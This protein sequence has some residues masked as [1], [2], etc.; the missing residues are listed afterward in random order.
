M[1]CFHKN[2]RLI[3]D[4]PSNTSVD[5]YILDREFIYSII[6]VNGIIIYQ[7]DKSKHF[8]RYDNDILSRIFKLS[9]NSDINDFLKCIRM[10]DVY[11]KQVRVWVPKTRSTSCERTSLDCL[12][13]KNKDDLEFRE[14]Y[15]YR[16]H[17]I[18]IKCVYDKISK[19]NNLYIYQKNIHD[20]VLADL[21]STLGI[22]HIQDSYPQNILETLDNDIF[23]D[24]TV[25]DFKNVSLMLLEINVSTIESLEYYYEISNCFLK[26]IMQLMKTYNIIMNDQISNRFLFSSGLFYNS[27]NGLKLSCNNSNYESVVSH[28]ICMFNFA[29]NILELSKCYNDVTVKLSIHN[30]ICYTGLLYTHIPKICIQGECYDIISNI[31]NLAQDNTIVTTDTYLSICNKSLSSFTFLI[32]LSFN[33]FIYHLYEIDSIYLKSYDKDLLACNHDTR[34]VD[35]LRNIN[36][37][38]IKKYILDKNLNEFQNGTKVQEE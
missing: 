7:N 22:L 21:L 9:L 10:G 30:G 5:K 35:T 37:S 32:D 8:Y 29:I 6:D 12:R 18:T 19:I 26:E 17:E 25:R 16:I 38:H 11:T 33:N 27:K 36:V 24:E 28:A 15:D 20:N 23:F 14:E 34:Y 2:K 1:N 3:D 13:D 4:R 31:L